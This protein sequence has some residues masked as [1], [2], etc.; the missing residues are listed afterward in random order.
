MSHVSISLENAKEI[1]QV[2]DR[3]FET[4]SGTVSLKSVLEHGHDCDSVV[5]V[6]KQINKLC[7]AFND[8]DNKTTDIREHAMT[9]D[10][11]ELVS[12]LVETQLRLNQKQGIKPIND[13][14]KEFEEQYQEYEKEI[15]ALKEQ[16]EFTHLM[17]TEGARK[18]IE[19]SKEIAKLKAENKA[20]KEELDVWVNPTGDVV[21]NHE[22]MML[23]EASQEEIEELKEEIKILKSYNHKLFEGEGGVRG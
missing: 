20:L 12:L 2:F 10:K 23:Y 21:M 8:E 15:K 17:A 7:S 6:A 22:A 4:F 16:N 19:K 14:V 3:L 11:D 18:G 9:L 5:E 1:Y 13:I